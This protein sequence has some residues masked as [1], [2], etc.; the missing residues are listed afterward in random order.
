MAERNVRIQ[1]HAQHL[2][3]CLSLLPLPSRRRVDPAEGG[4][5]AAAEARHDVKRGKFRLHVCPVSGRQDNSRSQGGAVTMEVAEPLGRDLHQLHPLRIAGLPIGHH[6]IG[7]QFD[8]AAGGSAQLATHRFAVKIPRPCVV[9]TRGLVHIDQRLRR[10]CASLK[11]IQR[12]GKCQRIRC[13]ELLRR[14]H[15]S[16]RGEKVG[17]IDRIHRLEVEESSTKPRLTPGIFRQKQQ[18]SA[19]DWIGPNALGERDPKTQRRVRGRCLWFVCRCCR[20]GGHLRRW[21]CTS[22]REEQKEQAKI[23]PRNASP[24]KFGLCRHG[25]RMAK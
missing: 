4:G 16:V 24:G 1:H 2:Q 13:T 20:F 15:N 22:P 18:N 6:P 5:M 8:A 3:W 7:H 19:R 25:P 9:I 23:D 12:T 11:T 17:G 14:K 21:M 10:P